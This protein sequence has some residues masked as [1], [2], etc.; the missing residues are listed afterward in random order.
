MRLRCLKRNH[1]NRRV[2]QARPHTALLTPTVTEPHEQDSLFAENVDTDAL[3]ARSKQL[4]DTKAYFDYLS[5]NVENAENKKI[6]RKA[7]AEVSAIEQ[8]LA[9][10]GL[11]RHEN[12]C[13]VTRNTKCSFGSCSCFGKARTIECR[14]GGR[15]ISVVLSALA[16][17][18][19]TDS[20]AL[21]DAIDQAATVLSAESE[22]CRKAE[23]DQRQV[24]IGWLIQVISVAAEAAAVAFIILVGA[25]VTQTLLDTAINTRE[26]V[27]KLERPLSSRSPYLRNL[28]SA[29]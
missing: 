21:D 19:A 15:S 1:L 9:E 6:I 25:D 10:A 24:W 22:K 2:L 4:D 23:L 13:A 27:Q 14:E 5:S 29:I 28:S 26:M 16:R 3:K 7:I 17:H 12:V 20:W 8:L 11:F 18:A